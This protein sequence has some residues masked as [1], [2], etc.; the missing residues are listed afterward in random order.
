MYLV[1]LFF[2]SDSLDSV[3]MAI[4]I[5]STTLTL[6][7]LVAYLIPEEIIQKNMEGSTKDAM[8]VRG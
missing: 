6:E 2:F 1:V 7:Y 8:M 5:N 3:V 4:W